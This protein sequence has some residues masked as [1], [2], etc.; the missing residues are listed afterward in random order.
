MA[1]TYA[2]Q[3]VAQ[4]LAGIPRDFARTFLARFRPIRPTVL[5]FN[6]TFVCDAQC[7]MCGNWKR[8]PAVPDMK[9]DEI[10][11]VFDSP[12]W[13][14]IENLHISG[15]EPTTRDDL[16]DACQAILHRLPKLRKLGLS[17]TGLTPDRAIP[18]LTRIV[19]LCAERSVL[20][21][22]RV[23]ID[24]VGRVHNDVRQVPR[25]FERAVATIRGM[26]VLQRGYR[27][28]LGIAST[29][30]PANLGEA[31][32]ILN[33]AR[34]ENLDVVFNMVR[35]TDPMLG[36]S[37]L[38][39][40]CRPVGADEQRMRQFFLERVRKD[41]PFDGQS[42]IYMHYADM[43]SN[44]YHRL[45]PCPFQ[46]QG[47]MLNPDGALFFCE[48]SPMIG[49][50][51]KHD[52][53]DLY[54]SDSHQARRDCVREEQCP[55]CLSPCQINVSAMKQVAPYARFLLRAA[56]HKALH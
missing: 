16:V 22:V 55:S 26:Q 36:N 40:T 13:N 4:A 35:F 38:T 34:E 24:G 11:R 50:V 48:N 21:S 8:G 2:P 51:L 7:R 15:G 44:G 1:Q 18:M 6:C 53:G 54:F 29:V 43:I 23:A 32:N 49:N 41:S 17:T 25:G 39:A 28:N 20:C 42:Y 56:Y 46:T 33:W 52:P 27:F 37:D 45:A 19:Q 3:Y 47:L 30:F 9:I 31:G 5:I 12:F 10:R 14:D